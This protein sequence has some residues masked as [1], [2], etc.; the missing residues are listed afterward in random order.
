MYVKIIDFLWEFYHNIREHEKY[1]PEYTMIYLIKSVKQ[2]GEIIREERK[3]QKILQQDL[4]DLSGVS[5]HFLSN[6]ENGKPTTELQKVLHVLRNLGIEVQL[7]TRLP[8]DNA[9]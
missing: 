3:R 1:D 4:A 9:S 5:S 2:I 8:G 7:K 6:L